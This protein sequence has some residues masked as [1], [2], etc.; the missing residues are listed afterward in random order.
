MTTTDHLGMALVA[1]NQSQKEV[2]VNQAL[3]AIDAILNTGAIDKDLAT[4]PGS[5]AS[6]D[7][8]IVAASATGAWSGKDGQVAYYNQTWKFIVPHEGL[9]LWV[10]DENKIYSYNGT[11]WVKFGV[12]SL[13]DLDDVAITSANTNQVLQHNGTV[14]VNTSTPNNINSFGVNTTA[15]TT[16]KL[17]VASSAVLFSH[18]GSNSQVKINK[19]AAGD[20]ASFLFQTNFSG[21]A[22]FGA[23]GDDNFQLKVSP[24]GSTFY[25]AMVVD[26]S[27]GNID[28]KKN[29]T[30]TGTLQ[31]TNMGD[32]TLTRP[33]L[34][35]YAE[36]RTSANSST[37]YTINM[38]NGNVFEITL[39]G[40]CTFTFSN[41]PA[42]GKGGSFTL[43]L[44]QDGTGGRTVT[45]PAA[46]DWAGGS[47]PVVTSAANAV[48]I[49][50]FLT[51][52]AG[53]RWYGFLSGG[54]MK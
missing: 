26:K 38:E 30:I 48:D 37:S 52:D 3:V 16:N 20:T 46:V 49:L 35:D 10:N 27:T 34:K 14:F 41:P 54:D 28:L 50:V 15:D 45:W 1:Q 39:T 6:G 13:D 2:T 36:T 23:V 29:V 11:S 4:P 17:A 33:E 8:Y 18:N 25:Q 21:R 22:E 19:N 9:S 51:T 5:P 31:A 7:V 12:Q 42:T 43:I 44:K 47:A 32:N 24:D 40:N 53:T